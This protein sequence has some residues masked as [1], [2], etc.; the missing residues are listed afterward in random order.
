MKRPSKDSDEANRFP[1][2]AD[3]LSASSHRPA[4]GETVIQFPSPAAFAGAREGA[5]VSSASASSTFIPL[6]DLTHA[7][8]LRLAG[9]YPRIRVERAAE[10]ALAAR[11]GDQPA[12]WEDEERR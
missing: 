7:V 6:G 3:E 1:Q 11:S 5:G 2:A 8:V 9:G 4:A 10:E 12:A